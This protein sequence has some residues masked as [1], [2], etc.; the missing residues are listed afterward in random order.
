MEINSSAMN[1][2]TQTM[3]V[4][5]EKNM[6]NTSESWLCYYEYL[7]NGGKIGGGFLGRRGSRD[8]VVL[9]PPPQSPS[10]VGF[11]RRSHWNRFHGD[12]RRCRLIDKLGLEYFPDLMSWN[13]HKR[14]GEWQRIVE[15]FN[16]K[17]KQMR[18][19]SWLASRSDWTINI[20]QH[21][22]A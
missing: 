17:T 19:R 9:P 15:I 13:L 20:D 11:K 4:S 16:S 5:Q 7:N 18:N 6:N 8:L 10:T 12:R 2:S 3:K 22:L 14:T 21:K 1:S